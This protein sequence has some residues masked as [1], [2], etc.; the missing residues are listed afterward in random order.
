MPVSNEEKMVN[1]LKEEKEN[2][3]LNEVNNKIKKKKSF[4]N[5]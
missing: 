3:L 4:T 2:D 5:S 1:R